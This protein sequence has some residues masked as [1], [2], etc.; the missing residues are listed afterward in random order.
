VG[1]NVIMSNLRKFRRTAQLRAAT[2]WQVVD[3]S[4]INIQNEARYIIDR[5]KNREARIVRLSH[6]VFFSTATGDAWLLDP[7]DQFALCLVQDGKEQ[8][9]TITENPTRFAIE[10]TADYRIEGDVFVVTDRSGRV[11][12]LLG[13]PTA[14]IELRSN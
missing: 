10:C 14:E 7:E 8:P 11:K 4:E 1:N 12:T 3:R 13:Y 9:C 2:N 6:L 5:A